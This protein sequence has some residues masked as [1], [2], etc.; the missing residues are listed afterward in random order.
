MSASL[1]AM[2]DRD[3]LAGLGLWFAIPYTVACLAL[4]GW[5]LWKTRR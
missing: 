5:M 4:V 2:A 3:T 1:F